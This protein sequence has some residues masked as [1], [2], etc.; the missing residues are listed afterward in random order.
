MVNLASFCRTSLRSA[1][2][3]F[4]KKCF[5]ARL[6]ILLALVLT[7]CATPD[8]A[9]ARGELLRPWIELTGASPGALQG[10]TAERGGYVKL[11]Y[12]TAVSARNNDIYLVDAG[13]RRILRYNGAQQTLAR[14]T[15]LT[16]DDRAS[17]YAAPDMSVYVTDPAGGQVLHFAWDG[18]SLPALS[19]PGNLARPISVAADEGGG[20][21]LVADGLYDQIVV[22]NNMGMLLSVIKP[23]QVRAIAAIAPGPDGI[24]VV[25]RLARRV[26]VLGWGG[27]FRY[28]FGA[29]DLKS[30]GAIA[31]SR[32]NLVFVGDNFDHTVK[33]YH[34]GLLLSKAGGAG[35]AP[36]S[37]SAIAGLAVDG[38]L[39]YVADSLNARVQVM[40]I[41]SRP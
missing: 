31:V 4:L 29:G 16:P 18:A 15:T 6:C 12:P 11:G 28:A 7:G 30:P 1:L 36:G 27:E 26:A 14:F 37:F 21:V 40:L 22:F 41:D 38:N 23:Q 39:L 5:Q 24:Y 9:T 3:K 33:V 17:V 32:D 34:D 13:L 10:G 19:A 20:R 8:T 35:V 2:K 25:D